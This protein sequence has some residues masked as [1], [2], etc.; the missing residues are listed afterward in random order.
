MS[1]IK[2]HI[3]NGEVLYWY[4][5]LLLVYRPSNKGGDSYKL[6]NVAMVITI[7][8]SD[9]LMSIMT[10]NQLLCS[11]VVVNN[12]IRSSLLCCDHNG[13]QAARFI[14]III[15]IITNHFVL[16]LVFQVVLSTAMLLYLI[17]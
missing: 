11:I 2:S 14:I 5:Q 13:H 17:N 6:P 16:F 15:I 10:N 1:S 7:D 4:K 9:W 8:I 3:D 12:T